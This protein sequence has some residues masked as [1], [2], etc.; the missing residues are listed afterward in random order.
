MGHSKSVEGGTSFQRIGS[1]QIGLAKSFDNLSTKHI[2]KK[3]Y[4]SKKGRFDLP[5]Q[6]SR[7]RITNT[8]PAPLHHPMSVL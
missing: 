1:R 3:N 2:L 8:T 6:G 7:L 4:I 5:L